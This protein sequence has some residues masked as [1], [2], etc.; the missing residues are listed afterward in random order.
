MTLSILQV[1]PSRITLNSWA[2][3]GIYFLLVFIAVYVSDVIKKI[4]TALNKDA[5]SNYITTEAK[6]KAI[7]LNINGIINC[8]SK[9]DILTWNKGAYKI[10]GYEE[11]S[12][13]GKCLTMILNEKSRTFYKENFK[14]WVDT[15]FSEIFGKPIKIMGITKS[16]K[17]I[18]L[19]ITLSQWKNENNIYFTAIVIDV[20]EQKKLEYELEKL[21]NLY[22]E[23]ENI[24]RYGAWKWNLIT[25]EVFTTQGFRDIYEISAGSESYSESISRIHYEDREKVEQTIKNGIKNLSDYSMKYR[26]VG[27]DGRIK[28]IL[29]KARVWI[30]ESGVEKIYGVIKEIKE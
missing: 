28:L 5:I 19:E 14:Q 17:E 6:L 1:D 4:K 7:D 21:M 29:N 20:T 11:Y 26:I 13:A 2:I 22:K 9:G 25:D 27:K 3:A 15:G 8:D 10:F 24:E 12:V 16:K 23:A 30:G 18:P